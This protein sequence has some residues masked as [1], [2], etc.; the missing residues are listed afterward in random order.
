[1]LRCFFL[2][3]LIVLTPFAAGVGGELTADFLMDT[4]PEFP[5]PALAKRFTRDFQ[6][7]WLQALKKPEVDLQRMTAETVARAHLHGIPGLTALIPELETI[8]TANYSHPSARFA[9]ARALIVLESRD[10]AAKLFE[11]S[12][13]QGSDLRQLVEPALAKWDFSPVRAVWMA[14][15]LSPKTELTETILAIHGLGQVRDP[16]AIPVLSSIFRDSLRSASLRIEAAQAAGTIMDAG[17]EGDARQLFASLTPSPVVN[18]L[19]A[20]RLLERHSSDEARQILVQLAQEFDPSFSA[21]AMKRLNELDPELV[22]P[23]ADTGMGHADQHLREQAAHSYFLRPSVERIQRLAI[24]LGD[25]HPAIR[26]RVAAGLF[27]LSQ[28]PEFDETIRTSAMLVLNS[29]RWQGQSQGALL[30]GQLQHG[31]AADRCVTLLESNRPEVMI[32]V[33]WALRKLAEPRTAVAIV[34]KIRRQTAERKLRP[35]RGVDEQVGHLFEACGVMKIK[36]AEPLILGYVPK[37]L[38]MIRSR[39]GAIWALG[40]LHLGV[41]DDNLSNQL[42]GRYL[43][44]QANYPEHPLIKQASVVA[45]ARMD[46]KQQAE[47]LRKFLTPRPSPTPLGLA[48]RW[49]ARELTGEEFPEPEPDAYPQGVWFLEPLD[50]TKEHAP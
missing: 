16:A 48:T 39:G 43:D 25:P 33:A 1:M 36:E 7:L 8:F 31:A 21:D 6:G 45:I 32:A 3:A 15:L 42:I 22:T 24:L 28:K 5:A 2:W 44:D 20:V 18:R 38:T 13:K 14:R 46:A 49:A 27:E 47:V 29:D 50:V 12:Q 41:P 34:D 4:D 35:I 11:I 37:D 10:S 26:Q 23:L 9:A 30:L 17:L 19:C 40:Q